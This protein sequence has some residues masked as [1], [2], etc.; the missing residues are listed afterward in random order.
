MKKKNKNKKH[1]KLVGF[2]RKQDDRVAE[3]FSLFDRGK[4]GRILTRELGLVLRILDKHPT[5]LELHQ[6]IE[7][8]DPR[9]RGCITCGELRSMLKREM[10]PPVEED[11]LLNAFKV[12]D[13]DKNGFISAPEFHHDMLTLGEKMTEDEAKELI[14][15]ADIN[16]DGLIDYAEFVSML[17]TEI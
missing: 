15:E 16:G 3:V 4:G 12:F 7:E 6:L 11:V 14:L 17:M 2:C 8:Y 9:K 10:S 13:I 1:T 5:E